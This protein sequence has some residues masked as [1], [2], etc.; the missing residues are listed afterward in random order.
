MAA[1]STAMLDADG[2]ECACARKCLLRAI[3]LRRILKT[4]GTS[5]QTQQEPP[6]VLH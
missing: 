1:P 5:N 3:F 6:T 2:E 4:V